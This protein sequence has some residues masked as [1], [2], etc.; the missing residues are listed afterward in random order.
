MHEY[1]SYLSTLDKAAADGEAKGEAKGK[2][3]KSA[4]IAL[5]MKK[6]GLDVALIVEMTG[7]SPAQIKRLK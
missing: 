2:A 4:E 3:K 6:K 5:K 7:L 1:W